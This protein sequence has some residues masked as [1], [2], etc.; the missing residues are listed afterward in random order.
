MR[1]DVHTQFLT[2]WQMWLEENYMYY[3]PVLYK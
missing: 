3:S 1:N 2:C